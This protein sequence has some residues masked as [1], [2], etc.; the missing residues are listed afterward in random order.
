[1]NVFPDVKVYPPYFTAICDIFSALASGASTFKEI[2][3]DLRIIRSLALLLVS[4]NSDLPTWPEAARWAG[5][6][7]S[8]GG[9]LVQPNAITIITRKRPIFIVSLQDSKRGN[10]RDQLRIFKTLL[11]R[12]PRHINVSVSNKKGTQMR[13]F[14]E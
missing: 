3:A 5:D 9:L 14:S 8:A 11:N 2:S 1:M 6:P 4:L 7:I 13:P 10:N 12:K